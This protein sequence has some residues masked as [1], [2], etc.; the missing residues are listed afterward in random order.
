MQAHTERPR[1]RLRG[2]ARRHQEVMMLAVDERKEAVADIL[3]E[4][5]VKLLTSEND[6]LRTVHVIDESTFPHRESVG[7]RRHL[8]LVTESDRPAG[9]Q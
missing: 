5:V 7:G 8:R 6:D 1:R 9:A 4:G 2:A 3:A